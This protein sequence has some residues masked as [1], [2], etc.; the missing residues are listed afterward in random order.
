MFN[1]LV[2]GMIGNNHNC[3]QKKNLHRYNVQL[4]SFHRDH[5]S[6]NL[7]VENNGLQILA[8]RLIITVITRFL[9]EVDSN[10]YELFIEI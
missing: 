7:N 5:I 3:S 6:T 9:L 2:V 4:L 10:H 8:K 1:F